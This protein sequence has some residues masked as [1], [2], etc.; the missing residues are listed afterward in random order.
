[1]HKQRVVMNPSLNHV[2][3][4]VLPHHTLRIGV[5]QLQCNIITSAL[6]QV[7]GVSH[8]GRRINESTSLK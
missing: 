8:T 2:T 1:M 7:G 6:Y 4:G 5:S 3:V